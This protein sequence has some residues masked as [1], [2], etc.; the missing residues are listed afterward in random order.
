MPEVAEQTPIEKLHA[1]LTESVGGFNVPFPQFWEDM[2]DEGKR[3]KLHGNLPNYFNEFNV[4]F[5]TFTQDMFPDTEK[6]LRVGP[7]E[8][9]EVIPKIDPR[10]LPKVEQVKFYKNQLGG[11]VAEIDKLIKE[12]RERNR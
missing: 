10:T 12:M 5:D 1:N 4:D 7:P 3:K 8:Q 2:K 9:G 11:K 6:A